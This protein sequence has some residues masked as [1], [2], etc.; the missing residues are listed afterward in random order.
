MEFFE[1]DENFV[2]YFSDVYEAIIGAIFLDS[3]DLEMTQSI[4]LKML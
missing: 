4:V 3:G 2:K 1:L